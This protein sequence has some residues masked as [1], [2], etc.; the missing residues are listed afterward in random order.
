[1]IRREWLLLAVCWLVCSL[2]CGPSGPK[3]L[4]DLTKSEI[5]AKLAKEHP[6]FK[7]VTLTEVGK[8]KYTGNAVS[9]QGKKFTLELTQSEDTLEW[10][11]LDEKGNK[12]SG[13]MTRKRGKP[14]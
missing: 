11:T 2:G 4:G 3:R 10:T 12:G 13:S 5:E 6:N 9:P 7:E 8:G 14:Q 1:M